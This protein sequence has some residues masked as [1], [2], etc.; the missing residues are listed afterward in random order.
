MQESGSVLRIPA[1]R[2]RHPDDKVVA[3]RVVVVGAAAVVQAVHTDAVKQVAFLVRTVNQRLAAE[4]VRRDLGK[5]GRGQ[6]IELGGVFALVALVGGQ[7]ESE[8]KILLS[9]LA[10]VGSGLHLA[11]G[12]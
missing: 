2:L 6:G 3:G 8:V 1:R 9:L 12:W 4:D 7:G 10:A 5:V 11:D